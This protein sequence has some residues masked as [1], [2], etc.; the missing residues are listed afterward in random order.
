MEATGWARCA[1][2]WKKC[3]SGGDVAQGIQHGLGSVC[4]RVHEG[5]LAKE[6]WQAEG[7][8]VWD[9]QCRLGK[10]CGELS[11]DIGMKGKHRKVWRG[12]VKI[13]RR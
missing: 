3:Q 2:V 12:G 10:I 13:K 11:R 7:D 5:D 1:G 6:R 8:S 4:E 9:V